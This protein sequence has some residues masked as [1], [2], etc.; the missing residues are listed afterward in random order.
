MT[1]NRV[2]K[3]IETGL[4]KG[5]NLYI[6]HGSYIHDWFL[7]DLYNGIM[8]LKDTLRRFF[9]LENEFD[10]FVYCR[11]SVFEVYKQID[12]EPR[13]TTELTQ[14]H[15]ADDDILNGLTSSSSSNN[16]SDDGDKTEQARNAAESQAA[17]D[18]AALMKITE[19]FKKNKS[20]RA[21]F[22]FED[23]EWTAGLFKSTN[24]GELVYIEKISELVSNNNCVVSISISNADLL[25][26]Y[27][28]GKEDCNIEMIGSPAVN[29]IW[30]SYIRTYFRKYKGAE[31]T[32]KNDFEELSLISEAIGA[33]DK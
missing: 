21:A 19:F 17:P 7:Y 31:K 29:E 13:I 12:N 14:G 22:F 26:R 25:K 5:E 18:K 2:T 10:F 24:D 27:N 3:I 23:F 8:P 4:E 15:I 30:R 20:S 28:L 6:F 33:G 1:D 9:L 16:N 11:N 32:T